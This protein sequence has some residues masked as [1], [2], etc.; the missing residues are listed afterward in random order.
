MNDTHQIWTV[1]KKLERVIPHL[2]AGHFIYLITKFIS[3]GNQKYI[4]MKHWLPRVFLFCSPHIHAHIE[5]LLK[6]LVSE[7]VPNLAKIAT[8]ELKSRVAVSFYKWDKALQRTTTGIKE[9]LNKV[10]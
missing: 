8:K 2:F 3:F 10:K 6:D 1:E 7:D 4:Y 5:V 9:N